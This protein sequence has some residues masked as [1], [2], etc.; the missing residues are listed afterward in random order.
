MTINHEDLNLDALEATARAATPGPWVVTL[1]AAWQVGTNAPDWEMEEVATTGPDGSTGSEDDAIHIATFDPP[2]VLALIARL[3]EVEREMH[4]RELHH[5]EEEK[6][7]AEAE[8]R[9]ERY[10]GLARRTELQCQDAEAR[11]REAEACIEKVSNRARSALSKLDS[12]SW[13][14]HDEHFV[15]STREDM[16]VAHDVLTAYKATTE[17]G[18]ER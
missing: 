6:L 7:R 2:T 18:S 4:A 1:G 13:H 17:N 15:R 5:F 14:K 9:A 16:L 10:Q 12:Y 8:A 11:L 3:R